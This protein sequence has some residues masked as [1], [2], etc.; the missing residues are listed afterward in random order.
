MRRQNSGAD[1]TLTIC[2]GVEIFW[3]A[4]GSSHRSD[5][6]VSPQC[7]FPM[8]KFFPFESNPTSVSLVGTDRVR[9][10][11]GD[12]ECVLLRVVWKRGPLSGVNTYCVDPK[13]AVM[14]RDAAEGAEETTGMRIVRTTTFA[15]F[16]S[17]P[18]LPPDTFRFP[19]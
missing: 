5:A 16:E 13:S 3:S 4:N 2:D 10:V 8:S 19:R 17:N 14:L 11:G 18:A 9:L 7:D 12:R 1:Q 15:D 6:R